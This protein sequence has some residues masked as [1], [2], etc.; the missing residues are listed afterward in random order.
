MHLTARWLV[1]YVLI[2]TVG[3]NL[4][5]EPQEESKRA[6]RQPVRAVSAGQAPEQPQPPPKSEE[7]E[8]ERSPGTEMVPHDRGS[9]RPDPS[10]EDTFDTEEQL[11]IYGGKEKVSTQRPLL[12]VGR[13]LYR[14]GP[15]REGVNLVGEKNQLW[16]W[17]LI[18]G[19]WRVAT[20]VIDNGDQNFGRVATDLN[21]EF[22][23]KLTAT[24]RVHAFIS[25]FDKNGK[26]TSIDYLG[27][28][29]GNDEFVLDGNLDALFFEGDVGAIYSGLSG[30]ESPFDLP[31]SFGLMP[32]LFQNGVWMEDAISGFAFT[33]PARHSK[34]L[35]ISNFDTTFFAGFDDVNTAAVLDA[36]GNDH[37]A[38]IFGVTSFIEALQGYFE[39]GYGYTHADADGIHDLDYHNLTGAYTRRYGAWLSNSVRGIWCV[40]QDPD[41]GSRTADGFL[42]LLENSLI[43]FK[44]YNLVPYINGFFG[45]NRPQSLSRAAAAGG[46]LKNTG[47]N[48]EEDALT[49]Y[50]SLDDTG[51]DT[52][53]GAIGLEYLFNLDKQ[54][55]I[56]VAALKDHG[57]KATAPGAEL[58]FGARLQYPISQQFIIRA[59][60]M[61]GIIESD[62]NI[63][64]VRLEFRWKF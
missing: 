64:G 16:P 38:E 34:F 21:L 40:G 49:G 62:D 11:D 12:E 20:G 42:L 50:P 19:D 24:E 60:A 61:Y 27:D 17:F 29:R 54:I 1:P 53:G 7:R 23:L 45:V 44:P 52:F 15:F 51:H 47:L 55:V 63:S 28:T 43:T 39:I 14:S 5:A 56:E 6:K 9:F 48:F 26:F 46:V 35:N 37:D 25:P 31:L 8:P 18:Y 22:D 58:G 59:D 36:G 2:L 3:D 30:R 57:D 4:K 13:P 32:L 10:Y 41:G 33:I